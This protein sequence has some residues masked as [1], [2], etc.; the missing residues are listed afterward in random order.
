MH[1]NGRT[2]RAAIVAGLLSACFAG[3]PAAHAQEQEPPAPWKTLHGANAGAVGTCFGEDGNTAID[4]CYLIRCDPKAGLVFVMQTAEASDDDVRSVEIKVGRYKQ[5]VRLEGKGRHERI[6][7]LAV[8]PD[9]L[10][11]LMSGQKFA[12]LRTVESSFQYSTAFEL[13]GARSKID[14][15]R[16][17]CRR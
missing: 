1:M 5:V 8:N 6:V 15:V 13:T 7:S 9:L 2:Q 16:R 11:A 4:A 14:S 10:K 17:Q 12:D 3:K